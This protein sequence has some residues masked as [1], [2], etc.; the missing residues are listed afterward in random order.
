MKTLNDTPKQR[1]ADP[2]CYELAESYLRVFAP[3]CTAED[4]LAL[5]EELQTT[6]EEACQGIEDRSYD[7]PSAA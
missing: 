6:C 2:G 1:K 4:I 3:G 7:P 5:A